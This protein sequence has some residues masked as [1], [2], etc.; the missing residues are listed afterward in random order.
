MVFIGI[1]IFTGTFVQL[2]I[3]FTIILVHEAG[4]YTMAQYY[5]WQIH[6]IVLWVF[7]GVMKTDRST[8]RPIKEDVF[9]TI[10]GPL[11]HVWIFVLLYTADQFNLLPQ[12]VWQMAYQY[13]MILLVFNLLPIYPLDGGKLLLYL[14]SM[15]L[16]YKKA[17]ENTLVYSIVCCGFLLLFQIWYGSFT[18]SA[19]LLVLFVA[20]EN[21]MEWRNRFYLL[22]QFLLQRVPTS[23]I[24]VLEMQEHERL[25][26]AFYLF[27]RNRTHEIR[28][29]GKDEAIPE[30]VCLEHYFDRQHIHA[31][32]R[33]IWP[34]GG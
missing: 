29:K 16:P 24:D 31:T 3:L 6:G 23:R 15:H 25:M 12:A 5:K 1:S 26:S 17:M 9:V 22:I 11:M 10:A 33:D 20:V 7:G 13:N 28:L 32:F 27:R 30:Q 4:H 34:Y 2:F 8:S 14:L 19:F 18:L 21:I